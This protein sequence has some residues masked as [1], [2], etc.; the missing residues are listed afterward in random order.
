MTSVAL[1]QTSPVPGA[2]RDNL[3]EILYRAERAMVGEADIVLFPELAVSGYVTTR[4]L[5]AA[6]AQPVDGPL[7]GELSRLAS[8]YGSMVAAGYCEREGEDFFNSVVLVGPDGPLLNYRK[9]HLFDTE[10]DLF[11]PG[12]TLP[13]VETSVGTIGV[14]VCYDLRFVE[15]L[16]LLSL[17]GADIVLAPAAWVAGFDAHVPE[18]GLVRQAEAAVVQANLDQVA[19]VAVSQAGSHEATGVRTLGGSVAVD[20]FGEILVGPL[21]RAEADSAVVQIDIAAGRAAQ[22]RSERI[23]PR[24]DRRTDVYGVRLDEEVW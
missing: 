14:C 22:E 20:A 21:S 17:K 16:R 12:S 13:V 4:D 18:H 15:V 3:A 23:R 6:T 24:A 5:V 9:L 7:V 10:Q 1:E 2:V 19:V 8:T 11:I